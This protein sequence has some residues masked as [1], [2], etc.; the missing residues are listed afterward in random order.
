MADRKTLKIPVLMYH[1]IANNL[2]RVPYSFLLQSVSHFKRCMQYLKR[3]QFTTIDLY[4][5]YAHIK[6]NAPLPR[7]PI[8][9]TF[10]DGYLDN[11][12]FVYPLLKRLQMKA[13]IFVNPD[14]V[15]PSVECRL[16]Q[17]ESISAHVSQA[18]LVWH[19]YLSWAEMRAM[20]AS[21]VM[22]IQSHTLT[23]TWYFRSDKI[24]DFHHPHDSYFWLA[25][26]RFPER[27]Y[28]WLDEQHIELVEY[29]TPVYEFGR[30]LGI[31]K[32]Y[33]NKGLN[34]HLVKCVR[35]HGGG[36][37]F[38][39]NRWLDI[40][41]D[42]TRDYQKS[43][44][45]RGFYEDDAEYQKRL[46]R[47]IIYSKEVIEDN[48]NKKVDFLCWAGGAYTKEAYELALTGGHLATT[49]GITKNQFGNDPRMIHRI[50]AYLE[51]GRYSESLLN[52][53]FLPFF[54]M[55]IESY[56]G[57]PLA[58]AMLRSIQKIYRKISSGRKRMS[59]T[60]KPKN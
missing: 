21:G 40:L 24:I 12:V 23:H 42:S 26:N 16:Q 25:W 13:T 59:L 29:G 34:E 60:L 35:K 44:G 45:Y 46:I 53:V 11:W 8:V 22:D 50:G 14:F 6:T 2:S 43:N 7:N 52:T 36:D 9:L 1:G 39:N 55:Q 20:Q 56:R 49:K 30:S 19:G 10:D 48:L 37:F 47:E 38:Q 31:R 54:I 27:K 5:L 28:K 4:D 17:D 3:R 58:N 33:E 57:N 32:Y 15:D 41:W 51:P 18:D